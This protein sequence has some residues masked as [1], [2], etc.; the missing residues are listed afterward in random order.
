MKHIRQQIND[1]LR[2]TGISCCALAREAGQDRVMVWR[3]AHGRQAETA[4][5]KADAL[6]AAMQRLHPETAARLMEE[7]DR[8]EA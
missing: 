6:R 3:L 1:F 8:G 5:G 2:E 7:V 4:S